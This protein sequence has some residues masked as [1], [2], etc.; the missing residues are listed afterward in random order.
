MENHEL[1]KLFLNAI[2]ERY[3]LINA[4]DNILKWSAHFPPAMDKELKDAKDLL[5]KLKDEKR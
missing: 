1:R 4:L 5:E 2:N 3:D